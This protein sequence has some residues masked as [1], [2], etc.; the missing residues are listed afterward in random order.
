[1]T[2]RLKAAMALRKS[3]LVRRQTR[4]LRSLWIGLSCEALRNRKEVVLFRLRYRVGVMVVALAVLVALAPPAATARAAPPAITEAPQI[5]GVA[6]VGQTL[7]ATAG[8]WTGSQEITAA[9]QWVSCSAQDPTQ[10]VPIPGA[11]SL[12]YSPVVEDV[13]SALGIVLTISDTDGVVDVAQSALTDPVAP[14]PLPAIIEV[15]QITE[16]PQVTGVAQVG[17][18]LVAT[19]GGWTGT[20]PV[21]AAYQWVRCSAQDPTQCVPIAG[22]TGLSYGPVAE[23]VDS[24]LA[25]VLTVTNSAGG[26]TGQSAP[27]G[28]VAAAPAP[29]PVTLGAGVGSAG[30]ATPVA[31]AGAAPAPIVVPPARAS[32]L[33]KPFPIV[34][35]RGYL[36]PGGARVTRLTV[37]APRGSRVTVRC[38]GVACNG[39]P[40][41]WAHSAVLVRA[42]LFERFFVAGVR[43]TV[44]VT[45]PGRIG[46]YTTIVIRDRRPPTRRDRCLYPGSTRPAPCPAS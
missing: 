17:Q 25:V 1:M 6:Q 29:T 31:P 10:C 46:K 30:A 3:A 23:D 27:T 38:S 36:L 26:A 13:G 4:P 11:T 35:V 12:T 14:A 20:E 2:W 24:L 44:T 42:R 7:V 19:S 8:A 28:R 34:R 21:T 15:P 22:A 37:R 33:L 5:T 43:L 41:R 16:V 45:A 40:R 32:R 18:V 9:Y 39:A